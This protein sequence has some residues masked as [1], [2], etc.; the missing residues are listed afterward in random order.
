MSKTRGLLKHELEELTLDSGV[1]V[2]I[3]PFPAGL[4]QAIANKATRLHPMPSPP[5]KEVQTVTGPESVED[6]DN[7]E[8]LAA[9]QAAETARNTLLG[10]AVLDMCVQVD[11]AEH[12]DELRRLAKY[13]DL[14]DDSD[15][16]RLAFLQM[17]ALRTVRDYQRVMAS[18]TAQ[19]LV[20]DPEVAERLASFQRPL[21]RP[22]GGNSQAPG[23]DEGIRME[24]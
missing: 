13:A 3:A 16:R 4:Y 10:E 1:V 12:E 15:E 20:S 22:E 14:S 5:M 7:P 23:A 18:A 9:K 8:Y 19:T 2:H 21:E 17:Y 6:L 11:M 24:V